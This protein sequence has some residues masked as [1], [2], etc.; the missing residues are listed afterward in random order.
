MEKNKFTTLSFLLILF[1]L[2]SCQPK[3]EIETI[4]LTKNETE[5]KTISKIIENSEG[6]N[7]GIASV[8][9]PLETRVSYK[10]FVEYI[11]N[12]LQIPV[13]FIQGENYAETNKLIKNGQIDVALI[14]S[15]AYVM[16]K[17]ENSMKGIAMPKVEGKALYQ[18]YIIVKKDSGI[19]KLEDLEGKSFAYTDPDSYSGRLAVLSR[20]IDKGA[21]PDKFFSKTYFTYSHDYSVKA[22]AQG[23]V[24]GAAVDSLVYD[25]MLHTNAGDT[26]NLQVIDYGEWVGTPPIV[27]SNFLSDDMVARVTNVLLT[28]DK[29]PK[30]KE[31]LDKLGIEEFALLDESAYQPISEM[32][33][34]VGANS[35]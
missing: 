20:L 30:G 27:V 10:Q 29:D 14:C 34:K 24:D 15:Q 13:Q 6:L 25:Q 28:M 21:N 4:E 22:V 1:I 23:V 3:E 32:I 9:S 11:G 31:I 18:S 12:K 33:K 26:T 8:I 35:W 5:E 17:E 19:N 2:V 16:G 7:I